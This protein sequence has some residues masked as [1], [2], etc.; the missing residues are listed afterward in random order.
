M[1][2]TDETKSRDLVFSVFVAGRCV[3]PT[4]WDKLPARLTEPD[5]WVVKIMPMEWSPCALIQSEGRVLRQP[6]HKASRRRRE[7]AFIGK[8][9]GKA[10]RS[11][12]KLYGRPPVGWQQVE[13]EIWQRADR[14]EHWR[15]RNE[16][17]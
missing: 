10:Y 6:M 5:P 12:I 2:S 1:Q 7:G 8:R 13:S 11:R 16:A 4:F 15:L 3:S 17:E 14:V 9:T